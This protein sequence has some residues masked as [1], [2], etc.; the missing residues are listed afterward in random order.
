M[1]VSR[2][3]LVSD[4]TGFSNVA[5]DTL[6]ANVSAATKRSLEAPFSVEHPVRQ[7]WQ[8][9]RPLHA[10]N[11]ASGRTRG[12]ARSRTPVIRRAT[13]L[14]NKED[15]LVR[16]QSFHSERFL[17]TMIV[18]IERNFAPPSLAGVQRGAVD[19]RRD[20]HLSRALPVARGHRLPPRPQTAHRLHLLPLPPHLLGD[21]RQAPGKRR[22]RERENDDDD[23]S[24]PLHPSF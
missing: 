15:S 1:A 11:S 10:I 13:C 16:E 23:F 8:G 5:A 17:S 20:R 3:S 24:P 4:V 21:G 2:V 6:I 18:L 14:S 22:E 7:A 19:Q 9:S 12:R